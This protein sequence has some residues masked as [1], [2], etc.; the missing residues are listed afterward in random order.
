MDRSLGVRTH[1][2]SFAET[3]IDRSIL[4]RETFMGARDGLP[5]TKV[6]CFNLSHEHIL[7]D[8]F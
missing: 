7:L 2:L 5:A 8:Q 6:L 1:P 3:V 4:T